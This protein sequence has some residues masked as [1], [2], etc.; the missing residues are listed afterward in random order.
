MAGLALA[1]GLGT[2]QAGAPAQVCRCATPQPWPN[3]VANR[4]SG[5]CKAGQAQGRGVLRALRA[6]Q[7]VQA[8]YGHYQAGQPMLGVVEVE[9]GFRAGR[10]G[11]D[12]QVVAD[13][14][15]NTA[16]RAFNEG[17]AAARA[18]A[19]SLRKARN[20]ASARFYEAKA[21]QLAEQLD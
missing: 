1:C 6:G 13:G 21:R 16:I 2:A 8:F 14:D 11:A 12:G 20:A 9:G 17:A 10:F 18:L 19:T 5:T 15:R 7:L 4:W 3:A